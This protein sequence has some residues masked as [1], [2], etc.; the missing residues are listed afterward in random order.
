[1]QN[2]YLM[3]LLKTDT[4][5]INPAIANL[6]WNRKIY[7]AM[8]EAS[9]RF[10]IFATGPGFVKVKRSHAHGMDLNATI[11]NAIL[12]MAYVIPLQLVHLAMMKHNVQPVENVILKENAKMEYLLKILPLSA[13]IMTHVQPIIAKLEQVVLILTLK[14]ES[15]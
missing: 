11:K 12:K 14:T 13:T 5:G 15:Y 1:M 7:L 9:V 2:V 8:I 4:V 3:I 6:I 10:T